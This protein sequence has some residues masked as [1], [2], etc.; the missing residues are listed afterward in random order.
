MNG[1]QIEHMAGPE[2]LAVRGWWGVRFAD[3][4]VKIPV[5]RL[6]VVNCCRQYGRTAGHHWLAVYR[7]S[8][9]KLQ[10][11]DSAGVQ[12]NR[13]RNLR[14]PTGC[15]SIDYSPVRLQAPYSDTCGLYALY[16]CALRAG[17]HHRR[18]KCRHRRKRRQR[19][20]QQQQQ[21]QQR[22]KLRQRHRQRRQGP[23]RRRT[24]YSKLTKVPIT[25][26]DVRWC[27]AYSIA[28]KSWHCSWRWI[29]RRFSPT[30]LATNDKRIIEWALE[31]LQS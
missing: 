7:P 3:E 2:L 22:P 27:S 23:R 18:L 20:Q 28:R 11:F 8:T 4:I 21:Q 19:Q 30:D 25:C 12:P 13:L 5:G 24:R 16:F 1:Q 15:R 10:M 14:I 9:V 26:A 31:W 17:E 29:V 6:C